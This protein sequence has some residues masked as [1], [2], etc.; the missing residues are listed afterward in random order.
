MLSSLLL[1]EKQN[2]YEAALFYAERAIKLGLDD[3]LTDKLF[4]NMAL[5]YFKLLFVADACQYLFK[6][7]EKAKHD[8]SL[9]IF[10]KPYQAKIKAS[11]KKGYVHF[12]SSMVP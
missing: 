12:H 5:C 9:A 3:K 8:P 7:E 1:L 4:C 2:N 6:V 10:L 11:K